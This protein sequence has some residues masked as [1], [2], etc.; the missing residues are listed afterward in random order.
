MAKK[1]VLVI[2]PNQ[3]IQETYL[4]GLGGKID[5]LECD[6]IGQG[7]KLLRQHQDILLV[8]LDADG[9]DGLI[10]IWELCRVYTGK[11]IA[12]SASPERLPNMIAA[13]CTHFCLNKFEIPGVVSVLLEV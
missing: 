4:A 9:L 5:L 7:M 8:I 2:E 11:I 1:K 12:T 13:G 3:L 10:P 6:N